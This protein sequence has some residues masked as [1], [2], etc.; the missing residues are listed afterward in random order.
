MKHSLLAFILLLVSNSI[1]ATYITVGTDSC[2]ETT[3]QAAINTA[4][5]NP[6]IDEIRVATNGTYNESIIINAQSLTIRGGYIDCASAVDENPTS[7]TGKTRITGV[8]N[9]G[10]PV[11]R[12]TGQTSLN[13][14]VLDALEITGGTA[15]FG[16][17][18]SG[19]GI[20]I[21]NSYSQVDIV[22]T[23]I[24]SNSGT[25]GGGL[26]VL[27]SSFG[28]SHVNLTDTKIYSNNA[29]SGG[30]V[31]CVEDSGSIVFDGDSGVFLNNATLGKGGG[32]YISGKCAFRMY[33]G[34]DGS[35]GAFDFRGIMANSA[36]SE[37]GGIYANSAAQVTLYGHKNCASV[38]CIGDD[39]NPVS[40]VSNHSDTNGGGAFINGV[41][42][43]L[44]IYA[45]LVSGN[46]ADGN[47]GAIY[48]DNLAE[49]LTERLAAECWSA[50]H[51]NYYTNNKAGTS[52]GK[53][54]ML[55]NQISTVDIRH[56]VIEGNRADIG[57]VIAATGSPTNTSIKSSIIHNNGNN[58]LDSYSDQHVFSLLS[59]ARISLAHT[60]IADN[61][62]TE[63]VFN[64]ASTSIG[65]S[66]IFASIVNDSST[67]PVF[68]A[69]QTSD[70]VVTCGMFHELNSNPGSELS[71]T[72]D[73]AEFVDNTNGDYHLSASSPAIDACD[74]LLGSNYK[75][76]DFQ[77]F[78]FNYPDVATFGQYDIGADEAYADYALS[79]SVT[80]NG[81]VTSN[82]AG[83][84]CGADCTEDYPLDTMV[85]LTAS[86]TLLNSFDGWT[87]AC[88]GSSQTC[89]VTMN[90]AQSTTAA[91]SPNVYLL[92]VTVFGSGV[93]TSSPAGID[94]GSDCL[95]GYSP[96]TSITLTATPDSGNE[97]V[98]WTGDC[99]GSS[100]CMLSM[101]AGKS[102]R[103]TFA[104]ISTYTLST[105]V[106]G[107]GTI[108]SNPAGIDC[109]VD[110]S[111]DYADSTSVTLT[112]TPVAGFS[113]SGWTGDCSGSGSCVV[114]MTQN[115]NVTATFSAGTEVIYSNGFEQVNH[116]SYPLVKTIKQGA[117]LGRI[118]ALFHETD[119]Y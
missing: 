90:Q 107:N 19:G 62:A 111:E 59:G 97:F 9:V 108:T 56:A 21:Y 51:C 40:L 71:S 66:D 70:I 30:G 83:I 100:T 45:G 73:N 11:I 1:Y 89:V 44:K 75:D 52:T 117:S 119:M 85:T 14:I 80:G 25:T 96:G 43:T 28:F 41:N 6:G 79:V 27:E 86:P 57:T 49:F 94:C 38:P 88:T 74:D 116:D 82:P 60:T 24:F 84:D 5:I 63:A 18:N 81:I 68:A 53:G 13:D 76:I 37:G 77:S 36:T 115:R 7:R 32:A 113:F 69:S 67:G 4:G 95:Q 12:I 23:E 65:G 35:G 102:A 103:A 50:E 105:T 16:T 2:D 99:S 110:C 64:I 47:G 54:G 91:F 104:P 3:I 106:S 78:G 72:V 20:A 48:V 31:Y 114:S 61:N 26:S 98:K 87:G 39:T 118:K 101:N 109:G 93:V 55:Y 8:A 92:S 10:K 15:S 17:D 34:T 112:A 42:T 33:S 29:L 22:N 58:G 46:T